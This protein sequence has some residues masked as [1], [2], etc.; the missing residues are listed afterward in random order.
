ML[1]A[2][3]GLEAW[4]LA[5]QDRA[6]DPSQGDLE[7]KVSWGAPGTLSLSLQLPPEGREVPLD[8]SRALEWESGA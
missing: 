1:K 6:L 3:Q 7:K 4:S 5:S 8:P 2:R